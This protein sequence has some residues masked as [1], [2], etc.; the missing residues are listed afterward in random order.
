MDVNFDFDITVE[1]IVA[2]NRL[3]NDPTETE[4][5]R[6][7]RQR[8]ALALKLEGSTCYNA[9][10]HQIY[11]DSLHPALLPK[12]SAYS[13]RCITPGECLFIEFDAPQE[14][15]QLYSFSLT[16]NS[17]FVSDFLRI[18]KSLQQKTPEARMEGICRLYAIL[19]QLAKTVPKKYIPK[20][21]QALLQPAVRFMMENYHLPG[22][23]NDQL[24]KLCD[25]STVYFRKCFESVY[26][27][28]PIRYLH[29]YRT[30]KAKDIL[31]SD[32]SSI[33]QVAQSVGYSNVYHFSKMFHLYTGQS[34]SHYA[35]NSQR[36]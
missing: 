30:Q 23:T 22:I 25:I 26:G 20:G 2:V 14:S 8:W 6:G 21:K 18:E 31:S 3:H 10:G 19:L 29:N 33:S 11:T 32:F 1:R 35:K 15:Q 24:A 9:K 13:W 12:G 5:H 7:S 17:F 16:D 4:T 27:V 28:S 34:P 36:I